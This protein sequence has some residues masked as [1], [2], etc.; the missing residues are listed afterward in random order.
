MKINKN[1]ILL[2]FLYETKLS[3][4]VRRDFEIESSLAVMRDTAVVL[5]E[6]TRS[7][8]AYSNNARI[9]VVLIKARIDA[10]K[11]ILGICGERVNALI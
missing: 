10:G 6:E 8:A 7:S 9:A 4:D 3:Y 5:N 1:Q 2:Y 11:R